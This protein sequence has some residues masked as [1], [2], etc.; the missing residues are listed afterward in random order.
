MLQNILAPL[1]LPPLGLVLLGILAGLVAARRAG[2]AWPGLLAAIS[3]CGVLLL[4]T[5]LAAGLLVH[6]L[7]P[8]MPPAG[9]PPAAIII[10]GGDM[11]E[12]QQ[13]ADIG[14]LTL[15]RLRAGAALHRANGL[16]ILVTGG[17]LSA[18]RPPLASLMARSLQA[19][20]G[21]TARWVEPRAADTRENAAFSAALLREAGVPAA[22]LVTQGWHMPRALDAFARQDFPV[23]PAPV[24][25]ARAPR[26]G[27][28][29]LAPRADHLLESWFAIH[30]WAG[31]AFYA[32]RDGR[33]A[34][35]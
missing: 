34:R 35:P 17:V 13:G 25:I 6:S 30:E 8:E 32:L 5:P 3:G 15:E 24:R 1:L 12:G 4:A 16:P 7:Q 11:T 23:Q 31:R 9:L 20:F 10:L 29:A 14:Q 18:G 2:R 22:L 27:W 21:V 19:D 28:S 26:L 33:V